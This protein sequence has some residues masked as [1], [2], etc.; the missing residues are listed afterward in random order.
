MPD[1]T[2]QE[3]TV[4][5]YVVVNDERSAERTFHRFALSG[6]EKFAKRAFRCWQQRLGR[7]C[8]AAS[9]AVDSVV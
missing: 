9:A 5:F 3:C 8:F 6:N 1:L 7:A 2:K 4:L